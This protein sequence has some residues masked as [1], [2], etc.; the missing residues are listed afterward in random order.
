MMFNKMENCVFGSRERTTD[1]GPLLVRYRSHFRFPQQSESYLLSA[2]KIG[3]NA[4]QADEQKFNFLASSGAACPSAGVRLIESTD[5][6]APD[7]VV[8]PSAISK[9]SRLSV[10]VPR[11]QQQGKGQD[12]FGE[13]NNRSSFFA[14]FS[15]QYGDEM[16]FDFSHVRPSAA[17]LFFS[18]DQLQGTS[19]LDLD[20][21]PRMAAAEASPL[22][23]QSQTSTTRLSSPSIFVARPSDKL[24]L[25][26]LSRQSFG[27]FQSGG[28]AILEKD[29]GNFDGVVDIFPTSAVSTG[30]HGFDANDHTMPERSVDSKAD[31]RMVE[32]GDG[33]P[34]G[35][36]GRQKP[37][38]LAPL[39]ED[40]PAV[41]E[42]KV[43]SHSEFLSPAFPNL[44]EDLKDNKPPDAVITIIPSQN[45]SKRK[46]SIANPPE[47]EMVHWSSSELDNRTVEIWF[48]PQQ[49]EVYQGPVDALSGDPSGR[50]SL[51]SS[52]GAIVYNGD[53]ENGVPHGRG[54]LENIGVF[55]YEGLFQNGTFHGHGTLKYFESPL[56]DVRQENRGT[57]KVNQKQSASEPGETVSTSRY[58]GAF[59]NG[60]PHGWGSFYFPNGDIYTGAFENGM[61]AAKESLYE[62]ENGDCYKG[63]LATIAL[64]S[65]KKSSSN[66]IRSAKGNYVDSAKNDN[67]NNLEKGIFGNKYATSDREQDY[68]MRRTTVNDAALKKGRDF[69]SIAFANLSEL[70]TFERLLVTHSS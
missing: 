55:H 61:P 7:P 51:T 9:A 41:K 67:S 36:V 64:K 34:N 47:H 57:A 54:T 29:S 48:N 59:K 65:A 11:A 37:I 5:V 70:V 33:D 68:L 22:F 28:I 23:R 35:E 14:R 38:A 24:S 32:N 63:N 3:L 53:F 62:Y 8:S 60:L 69:G 17:S 43:D 58:D 27:P 46:V 18:E 49:A 15:S 16:Q 30:L 40:E 44:G 42:M 39:G 13:Q 31:E 66:R 52:D 20:Y 56:E 50:G 4:S 21:S 45:K 6:V 19:L 10:P 1:E 25:S 26:R 12:G 2:P